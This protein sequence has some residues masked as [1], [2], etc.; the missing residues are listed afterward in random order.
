ML[1]QHL[2]GSGLLQ[3]TLVTGVAGVD[4]LLE[5][6]AGEHNLVGIDDD[7]EI[8]ARLVGGVI[9]LVLAAQQLRD[10]TS[11]TTYGLALSVNQ[12]PFVV[13]FLR[14]VRLHATSRPLDWGL[15]V[16]AISPG[17]GRL[18]GGTRGDRGS[19]VADKARNQT[20]VYHAGLPLVKPQ[21]T[22][23]GAAPS[24]GAKALRVEVPHRTV[25]APA[26]A[27]GEATH[28]DQH[29][30]V[31]SRRVQLQPRQVGAK[32]VRSWIQFEAQPDRCG[33]ER[34]RQRMGGQ[35]PSPPLPPSCLLRFPLRLRPPLPTPSAGA[36]G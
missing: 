1:L 28:R 2:L 15:L 25:L 10:L 26:P 22:S 19:V 33:V 36:A 35:E 9:N 11:Q 21:T 29:V 6:V 13:I 17:P 14:K 16:D 31:G 30:A 18:P 34:Q 27:K 12:H 24:A 3:A 23:N 7:H 5:L 32:P 4:L 8:A 20:G